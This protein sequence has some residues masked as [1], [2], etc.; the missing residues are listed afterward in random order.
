MN[1]K[2][3][4]DASEEKAVSS[5]IVHVFH[6]MKYCIIHIPQCRDVRYTKKSNETSSYIWPYSKKNQFITYFM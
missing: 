4:K 3:I 2:N 6:I 1:F 5:F